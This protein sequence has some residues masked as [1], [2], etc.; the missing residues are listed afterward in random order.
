MTPSEY[1]QEQCEDKRIIADPEQLKVIK[2][3]EQLYNKLVI[4]Q[5]K[6]SRWTQ[7]FRHNQL[8]KGIYLWGSVGVGK[9]FLMDCFYHTLPFKQKMR[10]HFHQFLKKIHHDLTQIQGRV[11]PLQVIAQKIAEE[12]SVIC[13]DEFFVSDITDAMLLGGLLKA[14]FNQGV[15]L[16][17]T[18]NSAPD[19]LYKYGL[20]RLQFLPAIAMLKENTEVIHI[21]SKIDYRLRHLCEAGV[22]YTPLGQAASDNMEKTFSVLTA[23][24]HVDEFPLQ[25]NNRFIPVKKKSHD[26]IWFEF[27]DICNIPRSQNDYLTIAEQFKT[28]FISNIPIISPNEKDQICL[29][30]SLVDVFYDAKV[31]LVLS[32]AQSISEL[33]TRGFKILEYERTHSRLL[34]MQST[35]YFISGEE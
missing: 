10:M 21:Q 8:I 35:D 14:L 11:E 34:E 18:S 20:Q 19:D 4:E 31:R 15:S 25:I 16:V 12:T 7:I 22:F 1:Y 26:T 5:N 29:F 28:V 30:I 6:R 2:K 27:S 23:G 33:Y 9:T 17:T 32:A 24:S 13:F 3:L